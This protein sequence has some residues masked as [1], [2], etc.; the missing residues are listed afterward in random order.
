M[1][2]GN[3]KVSNR[4]GLVSVLV[5]DHDEAIAFYCDR[6]DF[7]VRED[8]VTDGQRRVVISPQGKQGFGLLLTLAETEQQQSSVGNQSGGAVF[9]FLYTDDFWRDYN[10]LRERDVRFVRNPRNEDSGTVAVFSDLYG[11]LWDLIEP[12]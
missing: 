10:A 11:N 2:Q 1:L 8:S 4:I 9:L 12:N 7:T 6:L 3:W 5:R